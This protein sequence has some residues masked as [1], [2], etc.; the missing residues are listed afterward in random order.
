MDARALQ[1]VSCL[2]ILRP[3]RLE[4]QISGLTSAA[5]VDALKQCE[6]TLFF[7]DILCVE[8]LYEMQ[9]LTDW[10]I[11][12]IKS[13]RLGLPLNPSLE[14]LCNKLSW[15]VSKSAPGNMKSSVESHSPLMI[16]NS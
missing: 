11:I 8:R 4:H 6:Q 9:I 7:I 15:L 10:F 12:F 16:Y 3:I 2:F 1:A 14:K 5:A 13:M